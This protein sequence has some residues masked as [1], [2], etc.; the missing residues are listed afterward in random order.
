M[1]RSKIGYLSS[2]LGDSIMS[3]YNMDLV[4]CFPCSA[5]LSPIVGPLHKNPKLSLARLQ[6]VVVLNIIFLH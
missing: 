3:G 2:G 5:L 4:R 6:A 1:V